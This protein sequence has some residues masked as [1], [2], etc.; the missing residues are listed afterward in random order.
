MINFIWRL[1]SA[2]FLIGIFLPTYFVNTFIV[3][4]FRELRFFVFFYHEEYM[5]DIKISFDESITI[6]I[7]RYPIVSEYY[8]EH[9]KDKIFTIYK[10]IRIL[11]IPLIPIYFTID[12]FIKSIKEIKI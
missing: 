11:S 3:Y 2:T 7:F 8:N 4:F 9:T 1:F 10:W 6:A 5:N 12:A